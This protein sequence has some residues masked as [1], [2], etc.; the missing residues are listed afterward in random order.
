MKVIIFGGLNPIGGALTS[1][2]LEQGI[3]T[4]VVKSFIRSNEEDTI[5]LFFGR[6][7]SYHSYDYNI[8]QRDVDQH[9]NM[10]WLANFLVQFDESALKFAKEQFNNLNKEN[11]LSDLVVLL[12]IAHEE[13]N[14]LVDTEKDE[15]AG[16]QKGTEEVQNKSDITLPDT[17]Y[18]ELENSFRLEYNQ[19]SHVEKKWL[20]IRLPRKIVMDAVSSDF[21]Y[22]K[23][24]GLIKCVQSVTDL[25]LEEGFYVY[26]ITGDLT[27]GESLTL[28]RME[29]K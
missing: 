12:T 22:R 17:F 25:N 2:F 16:N 18:L 3:E 21:I 19:P 5:E 9:Y 26:E 11:P 29:I 14:E 6:N 10:V 23:P 1:H 28:K 20:I 4:S 8:E 15:K 13:P 24:T 27:N 7:A